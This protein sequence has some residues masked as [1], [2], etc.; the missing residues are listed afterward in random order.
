[1]LPDSLSKLTSSTKT[2][3]SGKFKKRMK[4]RRE[5]VGG[6]YTHAPGFTQTHAASHRH[7]FGVVFVRVCCAEDWVGMCGGASCVCVH[8]MS[9]TKN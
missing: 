1:M 5:M 7:I 6:P 2:K 4:K 3:D 9:V 8:A